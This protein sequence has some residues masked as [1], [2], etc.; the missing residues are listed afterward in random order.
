MRRTP[1]SSSMNRSFPIV[2]Q[3][4]DTTG[5]VQ[6]A[7]SEAVAPSDVEPQGECVVPSSK[8]T[9]PEGSPT[10]PYAEHASVEPSVAPGA[11]VV[12]PRGSAGIARA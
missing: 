7:R 2:E 8:Q 6:T 3:S 9:A 11:S 10:A 4:G 5:V 12:A 1:A